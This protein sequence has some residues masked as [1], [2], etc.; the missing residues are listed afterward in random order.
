MA[1]CFQ[2]NPRR[3]KKVFD[4]VESALEFEIVN[5]AKGGNALHPNAVVPCEFEL[6]PVD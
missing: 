5:V 4:Y 3:V 6:L 1:K 2:R